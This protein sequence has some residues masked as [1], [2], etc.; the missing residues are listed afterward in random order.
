MAGSGA[1]AERCG[2][3]Q[4]PARPLYGGARK[5]D[6]PAAPSDP[7]KVR[8]A[9]PAVAPARP[10]AP[11]AALAPLGRLGEGDV[12]AWG[13]KGTRARDPLRGAG[14]E[15]PWD[16]GEDLGGLGDPGEGAAAGAPEAPGAPGWGEFVS[17]FSVGTAPLVPGRPERRDFVVGAGVAILS[18]LK[19]RV[20]DH[21]VR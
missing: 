10:P 5:G 11:S 21:W 13:A 8:A 4:S 18:A 16:L 19:F 2:H 14:T 15:G 17:G 1:G 7:G 12:P 6:G 9:P 3:G 20:Q